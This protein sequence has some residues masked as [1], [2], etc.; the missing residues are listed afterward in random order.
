[1]SLN[2]IS[3]YTGAGG[4]DLG[5]E[6]A[7]FETRVAVEIDKD[8]VQTLRANRD[9]P[10]IDRSIH[11]VSSSQLLQAAH[12]ESGEADLLF[13]GPPCQ[14]FSKAGYWA[15]G[16][17]RRLDDPRAD[18]VSAFLRAIRDCRPRAFL[19]ENV[20]GLAFRGKDEGLRLIQQTLESINETCGTDYRGSLLV[21]NAA[22]FG[23]PQIRQ[24]AFLIG[25]RDGSHF[26]ELMPTH[27]PAT[28]GIQGELNL[29]E[30][31]RPYISAW[32]A[33][34][35]LE[36][37]DSPE[38]LLRG[39]WADLLPSVPEGKNYLHFTER[40][41]GTPLFGWRRRYWN[42][43][44]KLSKDQPSWTLTA[45]PGPATGPFH[46]K[47]RRLSARELCRLQTIPNDFKII[48]SLNAVQRQIGNAV[49]SALAEIL[50][51]AIRSRLLG[52][53]SVCALTPTLMPDRKQSIPRPEPIFPVPEKYLHLVG[54]HDAHP[55]TGQ[56]YGAM[57]RTLTGGGK[58]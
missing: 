13:G 17:S 21:L 10:L 29:S 6:S 15:S 41:G 33:I 52:D 56:G 50:G 54:D 28:S 53:D 25:G 4:L 43:L 58:L 14:P 16:D 39:K 11:E 47:N 8:C 57:A 35:D 36:N 30:R 40:G 48:G 22:D 9:W 20:A 18:T 51:L 12:L 2:A 45:Q 19:M 49:P 1:M 26:G 42:F 55:G 3:L 46:W 31:Q 37:D 32:D 44:L 24:R 38:L 7:G 23:V 27:Q 5:L 34:G